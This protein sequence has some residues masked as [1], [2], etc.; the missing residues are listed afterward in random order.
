MGRFNIAL[1]IFLLFCVVSPSFSDYPQKKPQLIQE[2]QLVSL[3]YSSHIEAN[4]PLRLELSEPTPLLLVVGKGDEGTGLGFLEQTLSPWKVTS[5]NGGAVGSGSGGRRGKTGGR[6]FGPKNLLPGLVIM[7]ILLKMVQEP[8]FLKLKGG[9]HIADTWASMSSFPLSFNECDILQCDLEGSLELHSRVVLLGS[10]D[11]SACEDES[12]SLERQKGSSQGSVRVEGKGEGNHRGGKGSERYNESCFKSLSMIFT[13]LLIYLHPQPLS[14]DSKDRLIEATNCHVEER[15]ESAGGQEGESGGG[16]A[17][18]GR[19]ESRGGE[20]EV[21]GGLGGEAGRG[22]GGGG[23]GGGDGDRNGGGGGGG[24]RGG[25][26]G[27][28]EIRDGGR[29]DRPI[30]DITKLAKMSITVAAQTS[31]SVIAAFNF[32]G[33]SSYT[34]VLLVCVVVSNLVGYLC[35]ITAILLIQRRPQIAGVLGGIGSTAATTGFLLMIAMF[36]P[37]CLVWIVGLACVPL[38][39]VLAL[40][41]MH[42]QRMMSRPRCTFHGT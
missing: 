36:L 40:T 4:N 28:V 29:N 23:G 17:S 42:D 27:D 31:T 9:T 34:K 14:S 41:F 12:V 30:V 25:G 39:F 11:K 7:L 16:S 19:D 22:G 18:V 15:G 8:S 2:E 5:A 24:G 3:T 37:S 20:G 21:E 35:C 10:I 13:E 6:N 33:Q 26:E 1:H 38:F 32:S